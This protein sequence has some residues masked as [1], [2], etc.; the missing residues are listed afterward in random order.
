MNTLLA[1]T[2]RTDTVP[3]L[4]LLRIEWR[5]SADTRAARWMLVVITVLVA[6][7]TA[8]PLLLPAQFP[9]AW[10][11]YL[12]PAALVLALL[13]PVVSILTLTSEW[14]Q[15]SVLVT[16]TQEPRRV[17]VVAA[18]VLSGILLS[19]LGSAYALAAAA[20]ALALSDGLGRQVTWHLP[21]RYVIGLV[22]FVLLNSLLGM[23]FGALL[24]NTPAAIVLFFVLPTIWTL[25]SYGWLEKAG[26]WL[27]TTQTFRYVL[28]A[29]WRGHGGPI[30]ASI[31]FWIVLPLAL[32]ALR[33][34]RR[35]VA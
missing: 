13:L 29:D 26:R 14:G 3:F 7:A 24:L 34:A 27:D 21:W 30:L 8:V 12:G 16:F 35:E 1:A 4:R 18:K 20:G 32:G 5:K 31:G 11:G 28:E 9:Q 17:R 2:T 15:R 33:T 19:L 25:I 22:A 6:G 10:P 23:A